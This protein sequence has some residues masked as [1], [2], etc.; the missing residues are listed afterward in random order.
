[1]LLIFLSGFLLLLVTSCKKVT[2]SSFTPAKTV[3][4]TG[5]WKFT[6]SA[7]KSVQDTSVVKG[8]KGSEQEEYSS[9]FNDIYLYEDSIG[10]ITGDLGPFRFEGTQKGDSVVLKVYNVNNGHFTPGIATKEMNLIST[11]RLKLDSFG[12]MK[13]HGSY[14]PNPDYDGAEKDSYFVE[15]QRRNPLTTSAD[16]LKEANSNILNT[17]CNIRASIDSWLISSLS[18]G[19]FRPIANCYMEKDG[20]G[21]YIFG[22]YG[23]GSFLPIY[24]QTVYYPYEWSWCKVRKYNFDINLQ[25]EVRSIETLRWIV[26]HK[27]PTNNFY[28]NLGFE[29]L[30]ALNAA[31]TDFH[32]KFGGFAISL[33]LSLRTKNLSIYVNHDKGSNENAVDHYLIG[34]IASAMKPHAQEIYYFSGKNISDHWY[35]RRSDFDV[36]NTPLLFVYV[37][38]TNR[39]EYN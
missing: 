13:G 15:A 17:L 38:G 34:K 3:S 1:M 20:G 4:V 27:P 23:P 12:F 39:I 26:Q 5:S 36:C 2:E 32:D 28:V 31:I 24:T 14:L 37:L 35:L 21:Y 6:L 18:G 33:G 19:R 16:N 11:M 9:E 25:G 22:H 8:I 10:N 29:T 7:D 30:D